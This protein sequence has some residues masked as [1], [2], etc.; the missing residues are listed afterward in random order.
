MGLVVAARRAVVQEQLPLVCR[1]KLGVWRLT[2]RHARTYCKPSSVSK[3]RFHAQRH[4][5]G[6]HGKSWVLVVVIEVIEIR[7]VNQTRRDRVSRAFPGPFV[8]P[9]HQTSRT[10]PITYSLSIPETCQQRHISVGQI[11]SPND[12]QARFTYLT[13]HQATDDSLPWPADHHSRP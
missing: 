9:I 3:S 4:A 6:I 11:N 1:S 2:V 8:D 13:S 5:V 7:S 12:G 10:L